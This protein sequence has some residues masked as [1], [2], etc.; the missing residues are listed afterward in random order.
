MITTHVLNEDGKRDV[1]NFKTT[2]NTLAK[3]AVAY[4]PEGREKSLFITKIEEAC[5]FGTK[6]LSS[7]E[8]NYSDVIDHKP[9]KIP[10]AKRIGKKKK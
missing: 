10:A 3:K 9:E 4:L 8:G 1:K 2:M 6:A 7:M 5:F